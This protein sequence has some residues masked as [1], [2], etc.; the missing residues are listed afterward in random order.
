MIGG[1]AVIRHGHVRTTE[2]V[3]ITVV[4]TAADQGDRV[5]NLLSAMGLEPVAD[6]PCAFARLS[7][8]HRCIDA[9]TGFGVDISF[10]DSPYLQQALGRALVVPT[11]GYPAPFLG[12]EDVLVHKAIA[13]RPQDQID[14]MELMARYPGFDQAYVEHWLGEFEQVLEQPIIETFR[15]WRGEALD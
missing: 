10:V 15:A 3:D 2:D 14:S 13:G 9:D 8:L 7:S 11:E 6:D 5:I 12:L 1:Q 4:A